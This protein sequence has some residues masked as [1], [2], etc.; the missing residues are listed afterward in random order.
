MPIDYNKYPKNWNE[1]RSALLKRA[2]N[3]C[4]FCGVENCAYGARDKYG[5]FREYSAM[6]VEAGLVDGDKM[7]QIILTV[8]HFDHDEENHNVKLDRLMSLCQRCHLRYDIPGK[9]KRR[10]S[11]KAVGDLFE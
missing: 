1:L 11:K 10:K 2:E 3:K 8:K 9:K 7:I 6:E 5:T 4:K